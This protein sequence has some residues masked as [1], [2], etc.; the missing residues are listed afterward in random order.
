MKI[1]GLFVGVMLWLAAAMY[2]PPIPAGD[3][4]PPGAPAPTMKTLDQIPPTWDQ[5]LPSDNSTTPDGCNSGRFKCVMGYG[6]P[7]VLDKETGL[8]WERSPDTTKRPWTE[9]QY[10]CMQKNLG[11]RYGWRLPTIQE[12]ASLVGPVANGV[13]LPAGHPFINVKTD[14]P[15]WSNT[16]YPIDGNGVLSVWFDIGWMY[17][18]IPNGTPPLALYSW[19][20]R[21]GRP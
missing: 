17:P 21:A 11:G 10:Q 19:C 7:A 20:V 14:N 5:T 15:Y 4:N 12:L 3:L 16:I 8:V 6:G 18:Y 1:S 2:P 9:A 13:A